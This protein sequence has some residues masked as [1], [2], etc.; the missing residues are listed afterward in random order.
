MCKFWHLSRH[1]ESVMSFNCIAAGG[2]VSSRA[3]PSGS[4]N[5]PA[6]QNKIN[7]TPQEFGVRAKIVVDGEV[8]SREEGTAQL[9]LSV[10]AIA[11]CRRQ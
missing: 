5:L 9:C 10:V 2:R 7:Y 6:S 8:A 1:T 4:V 3:R 11:H